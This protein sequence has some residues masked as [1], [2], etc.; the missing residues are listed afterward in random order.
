MHFGGSEDKCL[1][2]A[3]YTFSGLSDWLPKAIT[4]TWDEEFIKL[5][6]P[7]EACNI[8]DFSVKESRVRVT[9]KVFS[10]FTSNLE[11]SAR[12][13]KSVV[14]VDV[15]TTDPESLVWYYQTG[16]RLENLFSLLIGGSLALETFFVYR[17]DD[18]GHVNAKRSNHQRPFDPRE[19]A[20]CTPSQ[21]ANGIAIW[22]NESPEF[23]R[24]ESLI[25]GVVRKGKLF[26]ET[27]FLSLAQALEGIHRVM[28][29]F[30]RSPAKC[31]CR[32]EF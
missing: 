5:K 26:V 21:L 9:V 11:D 30:S 22:L 16:I 23:R 8:L 2:S 1:S 4:E 17:G 14:Y 28:E 12:I 10:Q 18:S 27:E 20:W 15:E 13:S 19:C 31:L 7:F 6:I 25:L 3:R 29:H 32:R 24:V